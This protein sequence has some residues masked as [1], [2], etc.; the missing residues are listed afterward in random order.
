MATPDQSSAPVPPAPAP[1]APAAPAA[2]V[3][4]APSA[5]SS[6]P[7]TPA[8][9]LL[10]LAGGSFPGETFL[11]AFFN[12]ASTVR[13]TMD[14]EIRRRFDLVW[15]QQYE[16]LQGIWRGIWIAAGLIKGK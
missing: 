3:P 16:D 1:A 2:P 14:P 8:F 6:V 15:V 13:A 5:P 9:S 7:V 4:G 11:A 10:N 12:W